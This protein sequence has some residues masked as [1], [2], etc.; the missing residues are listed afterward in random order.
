MILDAFEVCPSPVPKAETSWQGDASARGGRSERNRGRMS[1]RW[2]RHT[3]AGA[4]ARVLCLACMLCVTA[5]AFVGVPPCC[6]P[7]QALVRVPWR[8]VAGAGG[9]RRGR[10]ARRWRMQV[11]RGLAAQRAALQ[12]A[13]AQQVEL[14]LKV[15]KTL[16]HLQAKRAE[17]VEKEEWDR[18]LQMVSDTLTEELETEP[19]PWELSP[20]L[21]EEAELVF[22]GGSSPY[23]NIALGDKEGGVDIVGTTTL[24][25]DDGVVQRAF[26]D[27]IAAQKEMQPKTFLENLIGYDPLKERLES[28]YLNWK[29]DPSI[30]LPPADTFEARKE[31]IEL[32]I[33]DDYNFLVQRSATLADKAYAE[34]RARFSRKGHRV[35]WEV[36]QREVLVLQNSLLRLRDPISQQRG[37]DSA[38]GAADESVRKALRLPEDSAWAPLNSAEV[39]KGAL[40]ARNGEQGKGDDQGISN[41]LSSVM[42]EVVGEDQHNES[43]I[44]LSIGSR[45]VEL[46]RLSAPS[47]MQSQLDWEL[48]GQCFTRRTPLFTRAP[49]FLVS[50]FLVCGRCPVWFR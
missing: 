32:Q 6:A 49:P 18:V 25:L 16:E 41:L 19:S 12:L 37:T 45:G 47:I 29:T 43:A 46:E 31:L 11:N 35:P 10:E 9:G 1:A 26:D 20:D 3:D 42:S 22:S 4:L 34:G 39:G 40:G 36:V 5:H 13:A 7:R 28:S 50:F 15:Q 17:A 27:A 30:R 23:M 24:D 8:P 2:A 38:K 14:R 48:A 33:E 21:L 44:V